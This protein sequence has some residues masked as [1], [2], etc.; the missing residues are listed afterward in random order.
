MIDGTLY[1]GAPVNDIFEDDAPRTR[2][3]PAEDLGNI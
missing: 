2:G 1:S 3:R